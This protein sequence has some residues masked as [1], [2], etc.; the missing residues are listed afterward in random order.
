MC[1]LTETA[2]LI[3]DLLTQFT[4]FSYFGFLE[5]NPDLVFC[6]TRIFESLE[7]K[8]YNYNPCCRGGETEAQRGS[9]TF[10]GHTLEIG[11]PKFEAWPC[12]SKAYSLN[13]YIASDILWMW[14]CFMFW[15][16]P[17]T[18][19]NHSTFSQ[20]RFKSHSVWRKWKSL[21]WH[22]GWNQSTCCCI[23]M[24]S[25]FIFKT[26]SHFFKFKNILIHPCSRFWVRVAVFC[27]GL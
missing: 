27:I 12:D 23:W 2:S 13:H 4:T 21:Q 9:V 22:K 3:E 16:S 1:L 6:K 11:G 7:I 14:S 15:S 5:S 10:Q 17:Y 26:S 25:I 24:T 18:M 20:T 8:T 19:L